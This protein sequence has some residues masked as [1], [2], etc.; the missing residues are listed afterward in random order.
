MPI[1]GTAAVVTGGASGIGLGI[2]EG[3]ARRGAKVAIFDVDEA[4]ITSVVERLRGDGATVSGHRVDVSDRDQV[5]EACDAVRSKLGPVLILV[6]NAGIEQFGKFTHLQPEVWERVMAVNLRGPYNC[7][8]AVVKDMQ[9]AGWGR[10][11]N[12]SSSSAK[13]GQELMSAYVTTKAGLEGLTKC[14]A[15]ELGTRGITVNAVPPGMIDT[16]MSRRSEAEGNFGEGIEYYA[17]IT[18][19][20]RAGKP[21][22]MAHAVLFLCEDA[23]SYITGQVLGVNGGRT[24]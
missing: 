18:P 17:S 13:A 19:V 2:V 7:V 14:L 8:Q 22:D 20:R 1:E 11:V 24:T 6:N 21:E 12:I 23:S 4:G 9:A 16:P 3:L 5:F 15:K 10:I